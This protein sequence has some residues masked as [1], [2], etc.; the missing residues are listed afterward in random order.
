M[1][2]TP[3]RHR[4]HFKF[5]A[6]SAVGTALVL[7][8]LTEVLRYQGD[9]IQAA[10]DERAALDPMGEAQALQRALLAHGELATQ[11][12]RGRAKWEAQRRQRAGDVDHRLG[13]LGKTLT[14]L[15]WQRP[16]EESQALSEDWWQLARAVEHRNISVA[17]SELAHRLRVEQL[18]Q[19]MDLLTVAW[20]P[21]T[22]PGT[23]ALREAALGLPRLAL[24]LAPGASATHVA[25]AANGATA[26]SGGH[27]LP[28]PAAAPAAPAAPADANINANAAANTAA[29]AAAH[30]TSNAATAT[31]TGASATQ[32][33]LARQTRLLA[34]LAASPQAL[35]DRSLA[36]S[37]H[38]ALQATGRLLALQ[39]SAG[40][41]ATADGDLPG[42]VQD[43]TTAA[44]Q[45][46]A[47]VHTVVWHHQ[48]RAADQRLARHQQ[49]RVW[50]LA[51]VGALLLS[52]LW[53][54][55]GLHRR[56]VAPAPSPAAART[57]ATT[58]GAES[59]PEAGRLMQRLRNTA[60]SADAANARH[61]HHQ[62]QDAQPTL[63]PAD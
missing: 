11:V 41:S 22:E 61:R 24:Q 1:P 34:A 30:A 36:S 55:R 5:L 16:L 18:L 21:S 19:V 32:Q 8:P 26:A 50:T 13:T 46:V 42:A 53:L 62:G 49:V 44:R 39:G 45:A 58:A 12:L 7:V 54:L 38:T 37:T 57:T 35:A 63:P 51:S 43:A 28:A 9:A 6:L 47:T 60:T 2:D 59:S 31:P 3:P 56:V 40:P 10:R 14:S 33:A 17:A 4:V 27:G 48:L 52:G 20:A 25:N 15:A 23:A 29:P